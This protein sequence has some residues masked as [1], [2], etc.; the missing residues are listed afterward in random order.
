MTLPAEAVQE[1]EPGMPVDVSI[2]SRTGAMTIRPGVRPFGNG[3]VTRYC[4]TLAATVA[5]R[6]GEAFR[7]LAK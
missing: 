1:P 7:E 6:Y 3:R 5:E 4:E 2:G